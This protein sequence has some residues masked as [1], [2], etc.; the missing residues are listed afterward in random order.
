[1]RILTTPCFRLPAVHLIG[2]LAL[3]LAAGCAPATS[4]EPAPGS[5]GTGLPPSSG[6]G[7]TTSSGGAG[8]TQPPAGGGGTDVSPTGR[9]GANSGGTTGG[10]SSSM[11]GGAAGS[12]GV[13]D[14]AG[15][16]GASP[17]GGKGGGSAGT[18]GSGGTG[19]PTMPR[20]PPA[21]DSASKVPIMRAPSGYKVVGNYAYGPLTAQRLDVLYPTNAGPNGTQAL[22]AVL[23]FHGGGWVHSY[24]NNYGSG[25]D[26]MTTF[27]D[28]FLAHGFIVFDAEYRVAD[29]TADG[30]LAP[31]AVQDALMAAKWSWDYLDYFHGDRTKFVVTG[32]SAGGHLALI[33]G[34]GTA[35]AALGPTNP[36][37][38]K[39][40]A[41]V[42]GY[43][44]ADVQAV[45]GGL[46]APWIPASLP[47]RAAIVKAVNPMTYL[48]KDIPPIIVVQG[49]NDHTAPVGD[50][51]TMVAMLKALGADATMH[52]VA[53]AGHGFTTPASA[54][55]DAEKAMF[56]WLVAH[57]IGK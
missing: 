10:A 18:T 1:M 16:A 20:T 34:M 31:A 37:D 4:G 22:P 44:I 7:G 6:T 48:R 53:G 2:G 13:G 51:R 50:S 23:M 47:N 52:E 30:A 29:N 35:E 43:G 19:A 33:V 38:F 49:S 42:D 3:A 8:T 5:G 11:G 27:S 46:A 39:I 14:V 32:A 36:S 55:P 56:D 12:G 26:H 9:G 57:N 24:T 28:R 15:G 21:P 45:L 25:K 40:A 54:W 17:D 41:I